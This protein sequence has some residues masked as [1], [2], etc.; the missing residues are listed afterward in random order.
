LKI[1]KWFYAHLRPVCARLALEGERIA[2]EVERAKFAWQGN[3]ATAKIERVK[4]VS[5]VK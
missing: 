1:E 5:I 3:V 4:L 2:V